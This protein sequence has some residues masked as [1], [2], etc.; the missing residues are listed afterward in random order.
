M[1][2]GDFRKSDDVADD[3]TM[4]PGNGTT[5]DSAKNLDN[6]PPES[7]MDEKM[8]TVTPPRIEQAFK[9][10]GASLQYFSCV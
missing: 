3:H 2:H 5:V 1:Q 8:D 6:A 10:A 7:N 9:Y 4:N